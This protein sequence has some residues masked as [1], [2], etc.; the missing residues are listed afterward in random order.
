[1]YL[2]SHLQP[3]PKDNLLFLV[4]VKKIGHTA[5]ICHGNELDLF[6]CGHADDDVDNARSLGL[7]A[8]V[9]RTNENAQASAYCSSVDLLVKA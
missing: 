4:L 7:A 9:P 6:I 8:S 3:L 5:V 2:Q 1:M